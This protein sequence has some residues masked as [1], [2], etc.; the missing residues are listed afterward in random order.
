VESK[1]DAADDADGDNM[2]T[3]SP[4]VIEPR[5]NCCEKPARGIVD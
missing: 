5:Q 4:G 1:S 3:M 2:V